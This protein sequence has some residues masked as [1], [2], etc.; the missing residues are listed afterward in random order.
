LSTLYLDLETY[1]DTP[2]KH[3]A[4]RYAEDAEI[5]LV[6][7]AWDD[8]PVTVLDT[9]DDWQ[10]AKGPV[11]LMIDTADE[12]VIHNS[13]FD[14]TVLRHRGVHIPVDKI[15]DTMVIAL[16]HALPASL[17]QL[18]DVLE[19]P[20]DKAKD[21]DG[22]KLI[23]LFS[24]PRPKNQKLRRA[25]RETHPDEWERFIEYAR[26][27]V[28]AMRS[29]YRRLPDWNCNRAERQFWLLDQ[30][31]SD[32]GI[33]VDRELA[34]SALRA[35]ERAS[36]SLADATA[37]LTGGALGS[38]TQRN[39]L[40]ARM[41]ELGVNA[42]GLTKDDVGKLLAG[43]LPAEVRK[44]L[45]MRQQAAAT[46]PSKYKALLG[47]VSSDG[48]LRGT[49]QYGG[50]SRTLRDAGRIFQPQNLPR[51][52]DWFDGDVQEMTVAAFK[53]DC[54]DIL[55][56]NVSERCSMA[57]RG[58]L[59][60]EP[61][62]KFVIAD[63]SNIE[64]RVLAWLAGEQWKIEAFK[65]YD[66]G[67]GPDLYKVTAGRILG[68]DPGDITKDERQNPGK[69]SE[70][71]CLGPR[72]RVI[73]KTGVK[74]ITEVTAE[75]LL[76]DG[77][78]WVP[79]TG[80]VDRGRR[81]V[82]QLDGVEITP[83]HLILC[84]ETWQSA[85]TVATFPNCRDQALATGSESLKSLALISALA[86]DLE[87]FLLNVL[88]GQARTEPTS[89]ISVAEP[90]PA[91]IAAQKRKRGVGQKRG[92]AMQTYAQMTSIDGVCA[93]AS[94]LAS[95]GATTRT[96]K[97]T[98]TTAVE[99]SASLSRG[100]Q[101][102]QLFS[103]ILSRLMAGIDQNS[104]LIELMSTGVTSRVISV[105]SDGEPI[106]TPVDASQFYKPASSNWKNV[107]DI[108]NVGPR[109][110]F[111]ILTDAGP[112]IVHNCG[113][114]G[115]VG[116]FRKMG[117]TRVDAMSDEEVQDVVWSWRKAHP[118][119][120]AFWY[121]VEAACRKAIRGEVGD[122][123]DVRGY[124][125]FD[126]REGPDGA[127]YVRCKLPSGRYICYRNMHVNDDGKILY[128]GVN[129]FT[130]KWEW[131][132]TYYGKLCLA[133]GTLVLTDAG[134]LPIEHVSTTHKL[135]DGGA[136]VEHEGLVRRGIKEV[137][138]LNGVWMTPDHEVLSTEGWVRASQSEGLE[139]ADTRIPDG[140]DL[141]RQR[142]QPITVVAPL[143]M[144]ERDNSPRDRDNKT[145]EARR[146]SVLRVHEAAH[147]IDQAQDARDVAPQGLC[148]LAEHD[149]PLHAA[150][151]SG[152]E[153]L[154]RSRYQ[155][156]RRVASLL[157]RLLGR[158][159]P[160]VQGGLDARAARQFRRIQPAE[161][162]LG[163]VHEAGPKQA[164]ERTDKHT[165]GPDD[166]CGSGRPIG[167]EPD[168]AVLSSE[169]RS[170]GQQAVRGTRHIAEVYDLVNSGPL[171]RFVV[172]GENGDTMIVH[173]CENV[174]QATARDVFFVGF[175]RAEQAGYPV[176]LRVHD[177]LVC[178][179]P[180]TPDFTAEALAGMMAT[181]PSW[182]LGLPLAA[183]GFECHRY[184]KD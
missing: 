161:L 39:A 63:L 164:G 79:N 14:R 114:G 13:A 167:A 18:C 146:A 140:F 155:S 159:G 97:P 139:R 172:A 86:E 50:A 69:V 34:R 152:L 112:V 145:A 2:I 131:L 184:R 105:S 45:K 158:H 92:S 44:L 1:S 151:A 62:K 124:V 148:G 134:W 47:A 29:V 178:E 109:N 125:Q 68:K 93:I 118:A 16:Q 59:V 183:T 171:R 81:Q 113:F 20:T 8:E 46:S 17:G 78:E 74:L 61:G 36:R 72:T 108:A 136:W 67:E 54:D 95:T 28:D 10:A 75:D 48:R 137:I 88:A 83:D 173:N 104:S 70:L 106:V 153:K 85:Q 24:K 58:C 170:A 37:L 157:L 4:H 122:T 43:E 71:A 49:V 87:L 32:S 115:S 73:T 180:D 91:A 25:T 19:V 107:Y 101:I 80:L 6:A 169:H 163:D 35:F 23:Q 94:P 133:Q 100:E 5:L 52:P 176:V 96:T 168:D 128:E 165:M 177:E 123:Y 76:W 64:G 135:W 138:C 89:T 56:G 3:G 132:E 55:W 90:A 99:A 51:T 33:A 31:T 27:D 60:A 120:K 57:V 130:R 7:Y 9:S 142:W 156:V 82:V 26:L 116:A 160:D 127:M 179:V 149:R 40:L 11:Q 129:Q 154:R 38:T 15:T 21:K 102:E 162:R 117:G 53:A 147:H 141:P 12:V 166:S 65:A 42:E 174:V 110:R 121:D 41:A 111:A 66:R 119:T 144:R 175:Y 98:P 77:V 22:K 84:G 103:G 181:N 182:S 143:R 30:R 150:Y 126:R